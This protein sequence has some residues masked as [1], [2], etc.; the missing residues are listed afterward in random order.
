VGEKA[1]DF[2]RNSEYLSVSWEFALCWS[3]EDLENRVV[4]L[5]TK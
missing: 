5:E 3:D 4:D 2:G 1:L